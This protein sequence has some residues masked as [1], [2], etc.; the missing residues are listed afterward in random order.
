LQAR[1]AGCGEPARRQ[2]RADLAACPE[3]GR[4]VSRSWSP[5]G[6]FPRCTALASAGRTRRG[7]G[8]RKPRHAYDIAVSQEPQAGAGVPEGT[9]L[10][11]LVL[12]QCA[13]PAH[14]D[15]LLS[16]RSS[17]RGC[18]GGRTR[19]RCR[20]RGRRGTVWSRSQPMTVS[21]FSLTLARNPG[22]LRPGG[23]ASLR[24]GAERRLVVAG[25]P[26]AHS[27]RFWF[28]MYS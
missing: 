3:D 6:W 28:S 27:G 1:T 5:C 26:M 21:R 4:A 22:R 8:S 7:E 23:S 24:G 16:G 11:V 18:T 10:T 2:E 15:A 25:P 9:R 19:L 17:T 14:D 13:A 20:A 12:A